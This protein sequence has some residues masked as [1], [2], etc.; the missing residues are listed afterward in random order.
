MSAISITVTLV[1]MWL[2]VEVSRGS[3]TTNITQALYF[4][5]LLLPIRAIF[6]LVTKQLLGIKDFVA[7]QAVY[8]VLDPLL[9]LF[10]VVFISLSLSFEFTPANAT[11][12]NIIVVLILALYMFFRFGKQLPG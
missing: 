4:G 11:A 6:L 8:R 10:F 9:M 7:S 2:F 5:L 12:I 1:V 3:L